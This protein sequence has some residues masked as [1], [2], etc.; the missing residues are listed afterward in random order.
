VLQA[1]PVF[2]DAGIAIFAREIAAQRM[3]AVRSLGNPDLLL[4]IQTH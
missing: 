1:I 4:E 3:A 2:D